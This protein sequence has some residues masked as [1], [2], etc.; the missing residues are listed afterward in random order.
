MLVLMLM[1]SATAVMVVTQAFSQDINHALG[2]VSPG[3]SARIPQS[4]APFTNVL[5]SLAPTTS[6]SG[7][8]VPNNTNTNSANTNG[9]LPVNPSS[10]GS[11]NPTG[12][13]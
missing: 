8:P 9:S 12:D 6:S 11:G 10:H 13:G 2:M 1:V 4:D 5:T 7:T 3:G